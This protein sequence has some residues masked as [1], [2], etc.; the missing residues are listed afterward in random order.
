MFAIFLLSF[1]L[2]EQLFLGERAKSTAF[3]IN[4]L[5]N[6]NCKILCEKV[7]E[8]RDIARFKRLVKREYRARLNLDNMPIVMKKQSPSGDSV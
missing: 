4:M 3:E 6:E 8:Q 7:L 2:G 5:K 1:K